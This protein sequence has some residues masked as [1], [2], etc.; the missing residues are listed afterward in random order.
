MDN[1]GFSLVELAIVLTIV[2]ILAGAVIAAQSMIRASKI[3]G[4]VEEVEAYRRGVHEFE[5]QY[6]GLPGD[7]VLATSQ[8]AWT[9]AVNGNGDGQIS[10]WNTEGLQ[11]WYHLMQTKLIPGRYT[12]AVSSAMAV[13]GTNIPASKIN[14][15]AGYS[16]YYIAPADAIWKHSDT[17]GTAAVTVTNNSVGNVLVLGGQTAAS[18]SSTTILS[19]NEAKAID[20]KADDGWPDSGRVQSRVGTAC[21]TTSGGRMIYNTLASAGR[22]CALSFALK[23]SSGQ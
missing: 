19:Q 15:A 20:T 18:F 2:G 4:V 13:I 22:S 11:A 14:K 17:P 10:P 1:R 7:F 16:F 9:A 6:Q 3:Q 5:T 21:T 23:R 8:T 12:G